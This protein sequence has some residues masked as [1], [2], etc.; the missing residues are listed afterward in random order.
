M[1]LNINYGNQLIYSVNWLYEFIF[2]AHI[3]HFETAT[4]LNGLST[5]IQNDLLAA[6]QT[7]MTL[8]IKQEIINTGFVTIN[9]DETTVFSNLLQ[10][11]VVLRYVIEDTIVERFL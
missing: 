5:A 3:N 9:V 7:F 4:V 1:F 11:S 8:H 6:M 10:M 2:T